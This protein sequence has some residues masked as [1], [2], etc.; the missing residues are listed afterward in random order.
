MWML[1]F[2][3]LLSRAENPCIFQNLMIEHWHWQH[4]PRIWIYL[5]RL[6]LKPQRSW[7]HIMRKKKNQR[8]MYLL[9]FLLLESEINFIDCFQRCATQPSRVDQQSWR[10]AKHNITCPSD[11]SCLTQPAWDKECSEGRVLLNCKHQLPAHS[12]SC[13]QPPESRFASLSK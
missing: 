12:L 7:N 8:R 4:E 3:I 5:L 11:C 1:F 6:L 2:L 13:G 9:Y 10:G